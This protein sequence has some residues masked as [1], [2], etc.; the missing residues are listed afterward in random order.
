MLRL[1]QNPEALLCK[2]QVF[3]MPSK[4]I[5]QSCKSVV[6]IFCHLAFS[7]FKRKCLIHVELLGAHKHKACQVRQLWC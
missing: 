1:S 3:S 4:V 5:Y 7:Y 6:L 2:S